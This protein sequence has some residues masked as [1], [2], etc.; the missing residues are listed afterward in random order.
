MAL[1]TVFGC[2]EQA[3]ASHG[4]CGPRS[5]P[6]R[7]QAWCG[8][9][10][11][12]SHAPPPPIPGPPRSA[13]HSLAGVDADLSALVCRECPRACEEDEGTIGP[14]SA[15]GAH[16]GRARRLEEGCG[17]GASEEGSAPETAETRGVQLARG[18]TVTWSPG[19]GSARALTSAHC[20]RWPSPSSVCASLRGSCWCQALVSGRRLVL[21]P[22]SWHCPRS[23]PTGGRSREL[24]CPCGKFQEPSGNTKDVKGLA[25]EEGPAGRVGAGS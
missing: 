23:P 21:T 19:A 4:G 3:L 9:A 13:W 18:P 6:A 15:R 2:P 22:E 12:S 1:V 11:V 5:R 20:G 17:V 25:F 8:H 10:P 16:T 14:S 24:C 7:V